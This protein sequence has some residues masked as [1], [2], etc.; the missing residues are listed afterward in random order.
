M[1]DDF[2]LYSNTLRWIEEE[3]LTKS[4]K[5]T[6]LAII[7]INQNTDLDIVPVIKRYGSCGKTEID[8]F[9]KIVNSVT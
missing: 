5:L 4:F 7:N 2:G 3:I 1:S 6:G 8:F 9:F